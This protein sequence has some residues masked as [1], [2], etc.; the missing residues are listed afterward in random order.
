MSPSWSMEPVTPSTIDEVVSFINNARRD[1]F[2]E[3]CAQLKD[4]VA[5]WTSS[6]FF[7]TAR[8]GKTIVA[9]IGCVPYDGRF[10]HLDHRFRGKN[11]VEVVRLYVL[12]AWRRCGIAKELF[13]ALKD[14]AVGEEVD[15][16]YLHTHPF[17]PGAVKFWDKHGFRV[18]CVEDDEVWRTTH[19]ELV[20]KGGNM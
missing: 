16:L 8:D 6:R 10:G 11:T 5:H 7:L 12:P 2:P 1:M 3:L 13:G 18:V 20:L 9:T 4:D 19:M 14:K 15:V 17:L